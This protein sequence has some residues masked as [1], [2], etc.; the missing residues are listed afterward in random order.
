M[1]RKEVGTVVQSSILTSSLD[2]IGWFQMKLWKSSAICSPSSKPTYMWKSHK[3]CI[4]HLGKQRKFMDFQELFRSLWEF[5]P[6]A[7]TYLCPQ[8][9]H[10][11]SLC[12]LL[13][14]PRARAALGLSRTDLCL[15][16]VHDWEW[17]A[18]YYF[19]I[20]HVNKLILKNVL[21]WNTAIEFLF[22]LKPIVIPLKQQ[23]QLD[24]TRL[25]G[26]LHQS[27]I[28]LHALWLWEWL[29]LHLPILVSSTIPGPT[30]SPIS[31][32]G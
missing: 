17:T 30:V 13:R 32:A 3:T 27:V 18:F 9:L 19:M 6:M 5:T 12:L 8:G 15:Q 2:F 22:D 21:N 31:M 16:W 24:E 25:G 7:Y 26:K 14:V 20:F 29:G 11:P 28:K 1:T 4:N 10:L 23:N